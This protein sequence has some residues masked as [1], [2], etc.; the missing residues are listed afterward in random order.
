MTK[1]SSLSLN[2][3]RI[4]VAVNKWR[5]SNFRGLAAAEVDLALSRFL[6]DI[7]TYPIV[8]VQKNYK[9]LWRVRSSGSRFDHV[10]EFWAPPN[11]KAQLQR[12]NEAG[13]PLLYASEHISTPFSEVEIGLNEVCHL[14]QYECLSQLSLVDIIPSPLV[15][16]AS[17]HS[18]VYDDRS[19]HA[20]QI[21]RDFLRDE[22]MRDDDEDRKISY[23]LT[24]SFCRIWSGG[25]GHDGWI[26]PSVRGGRGLN[27]AL[28]PDAARLKLR[29]KKVQIVEL[30][31][32]VAPSASG[33]KV[34][35]FLPGSLRSSAKY[36]TSSMVG[37]VHGDNI[38]WTAS[39]SA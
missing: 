21:L 37:L 33:K 6:D 23:N 36:I 38:S 8:T 32:E 7:R 4:H 5:D 24:S 15:P 14:I 20:Y 1:S 11:E 19:L 35:G 9:S 10:R 13:S 22:F 27:I 17:D 18:P 26:Y 28:R 39:H 34:I 16:L 25:N 2:L 30:S 29:I 31:E 12:C 3:D